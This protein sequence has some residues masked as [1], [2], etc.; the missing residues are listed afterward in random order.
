MDR[1]DAWARPATADNISDALFREYAGMLWE[2][3]VGRD[4]A[5]DIVAFVAARHL[6]PAPP[7]VLTDGEWG[8]ILDAMWKAESEWERGVA[9]KR[10]DRVNT[11]ESYREVDLYAVLDWFAANGIVLTREART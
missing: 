7:V 4:V 10:E 6:A 3:D 11:G 2:G 1:L 9:V 5:R 8:K